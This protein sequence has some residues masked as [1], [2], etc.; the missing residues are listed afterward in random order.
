M[1]IVE[2]PIAPRGVLHDLRDVDPESSPWPRIL[3][4]GKGS[5]AR[6]WDQALEDML[7]LPGSK[8]SKILQLHLLSLVICPGLCFFET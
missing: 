6:A 3:K 1:L 2:P 8:L 4:M 7:L 5:A